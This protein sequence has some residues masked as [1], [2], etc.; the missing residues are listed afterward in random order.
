[1]ASDDPSTPSPDEIVPQAPLTNAV[2]VIP[3]QATPGRPL[4]KGVQAQIG[5]SKD[6]A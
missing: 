1:M 6:D 5:A 2:V 3:R 4:P